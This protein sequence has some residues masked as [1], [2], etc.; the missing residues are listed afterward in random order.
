MLRIQIDVSKGELDYIREALEIK[1]INLMSYLDTCE[2]ESSP[3]P[4]LSE[5]SAW[6]DKAF[7]TEYV[8]KP[9][10]TQTVKGKKIL[11]RR[12]KKK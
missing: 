12:R 7:E 8:K 11:A 4:T 5:V 9:H 1:H 2:R 3:K 10:W 6:A